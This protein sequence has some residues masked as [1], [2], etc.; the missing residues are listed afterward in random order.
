MKYLIITGPDASRDIALETFLNFRDEYDDVSDIFLM[1]P[2][3]VS[4][5]LSD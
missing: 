3:D 1:M 5:E 2:P 4:C